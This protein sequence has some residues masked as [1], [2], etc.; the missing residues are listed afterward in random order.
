MCGYLVSPAASRSCASAVW[1]NVSDVLRD[2]K[3]TS[4]T[5]PPQHFSGENVRTED[6]EP[7]AGR[8]I[9]RELLYGD[10]AETVGALLAA[11]GLRQKELAA[12]LVLSEAR[13]SRL[14]RGD[15]NTSLRAIADVAW[16][17]GYR[18][19]LTPVP[20]ESRESTPARNDPPPPRWVKRLR[21][22]TARES[23]VEPPSSRETM[24]ALS[25][26]GDDMGKGNDNDRYVVPRAGEGWAVVKED[27][28]RASAVVP[29][30]REAIERAKEIAGNLG[31]GEVRVQNR[32]GEFREGEHAPKRS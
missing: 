5:Q 4:P 17:L 32:H 20:L 29:T 22:L 14:L 13:V 26:E 15:A 19:E 8:E 11:S 23:A 3:L 10:F 2:A 18:F 31:G 7:L 24:S 1:S 30:Q 25:R 27:H 28:Q 6:R 9:E 16:S 21:Q 12:R